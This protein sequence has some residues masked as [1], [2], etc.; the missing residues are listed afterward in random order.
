MTPIGFCITVHKASSSNKS[1]LFNWTK[2]ICKEVVVVDIKGDSTK[3]PPLLKITFLSKCQKS[4]QGR[5]YVRGISLFAPFS[6]K[7]NVTVNFLEWFERKLWVNTIMNQKEKS[8]FCHFLC[9]MHHFMGLCFFKNTQTSWV[10]K[11]S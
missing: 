5:I 3:I 11:R 10:W 8:C 1:D 7:D 4:A 9:K 2:N 6:F